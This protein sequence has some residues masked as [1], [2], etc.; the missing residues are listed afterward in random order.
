MISMMMLRPTCIYLLALIAPAF[1]Q[2][3]VTV[4]GAR[5]PE[6]IETGNTAEI[7]ISAPDARS[8]AQMSVRLNGA[9][10]SGLRADADAVIIRTAALTDLKAGSNRIQIFPARAAKSPAAELTIST[11]VA[12]TIACDQLRGATLAGLD[13]TD[14]VTIDS[15]VPAAATQN[16][17]AHCV[18]RGSANPHDGANGV[19][20]AIGFEVRLPDRWSGRFLFQGG[21][22]NDGAVNNV[23]GSNTG[24]PRSPPALARGFAVAATDGGHTGRSAES[25]GFDQQARIDHAYNAYG[26]TTLIAKALMRAYYGKDPD[27][28]YVIGCSGGGRQVMMFTQR[29]PDFYDGA[30]AC[31]PA[32]RVSSGATISAAWESKL[33]RDIAPAGPDGGRILSQAFTNDDLTLVSRAILKSCDEL[34]GATDGA[35]DNYQSCRFDPRVLQCPGAKDASCLTAAQVSALTAGFAGPHNS[36][37]KKLYSAWPWDPGVSAQGWRQW[38]LGSSTTSTPNSAFAALMQDAL[39]H[40][41]FTPFTPA[42]SIFDFDFDRDP[43][44]MDAESNLY[45]TYRDDKLTAFHGRGGKLMFVHGLA[46]PIFS[47]LDTIDYYNRLAANNGG[48]PALKNW[49]R[50]FFVPGMNHCA[51]GSATDT[52]DGLAAIIDWVENDRAPERIM[53]TGRSLP[54]RTRPLCAYPTQAHYSGQGSIE[55][56]ANFV[57]R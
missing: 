5:F 21:G 55:D 41:F 32:M 56:G 4:T 46:D 43:A 50:A 44:R 52:F 6:F 33:Y 27:R 26:K 30:V 22:G 18:V 47:P 39:A 8:A 9:E 7:R 42:F 10:V 12:P 29:F 15:A 49:A 2:Y 11:A 28:S 17:P 31:A 40:E 34:D 3:S 36:A 53:A 45:D 20:F 25:F 37:G 13:A 23:F 48:V 24:A 1:A 14:K 16:L 19:H 38:K 35:V 54:G 57:C 51:G